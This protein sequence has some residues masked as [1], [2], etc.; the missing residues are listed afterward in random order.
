[1]S[2]PAT[3]QIVGNVC[4]GLA[5]LVFVL[6]LQNFL[7]E[8]VRRETSSDLWVAPALYILVPLWALLLVALLCVTASGGFDWI[9]LGRPALYGLTLAAAV[10]LA[11]VS[12]VFIA[13]YLRPGFTP[14]GLYSPVFYLV[15]L[16]TVLLVLLSLNQRLGA[17][18]PTQWLARP[19]AALVAVSLAG[20]LALF[21]Y[22]IVTTGAGG[23]VGMTHRF[24][25]RD[26]SLSEELAKVA[27]LDP[28][29]DFESLLW[30]TSRD[31]P[32]ALRE[33][34]SA[35]LRAHPQFLER[36]SRELESGHVEPAVGFLL[37]ATLTPAEQARFA[38]PARSAMV[39]WVNRIPAPNYTTRS[40]LRDLR[41]WGR[42]AF[43]ILPEQF[44]GTGVDFA[45][46]VADFKD[47]V[48]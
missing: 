35:R 27:T 46:V 13:L 43:R 3:P 4:T 41:R 33:A 31:A 20:C 18:I 11:T 5:V 48:D 14:R 30:R 16:S 28:E 26:S 32:A 1:M 36:L 47:K 38:G 12:F 23:L 15:T 10:A 6:P 24:L 21:G 8:W 45:E 29:K 39:R 19:W 34:A 42:E 22:W 7:S 2:F 9:R 37:G 25:H 40:H 44:A 17:G